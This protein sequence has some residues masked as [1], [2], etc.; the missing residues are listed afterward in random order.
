MQSHG[1]GHD[2]TPRGVARI[3]ALPEDGGAD[4]WEHLFL[5]PG[6]KQR[7]LNQ[8][9]FSLAH[10]H[11]LRSERTALHGLLVLAGPPGTGKTSTARALASVAAARLA[12]QGGTTLVEIDPH[13]LPSEMLGESQRNV[14][15]LLTSTLPDIAG[16]RT[17]TICIVDEVEALAMRRSTAS[18][19]TNP[20]DLHRAT[21]AVLTGLDSVAAA[22][23]HLLIIATTNFPAAVDEAVLSRADLVVPF[24]VPDHTA[25]VAILRDTLAELAASWPSLEGIVDDEARLDELG[26]AC[27]GYD[28][29]RLRKLVL[30]AFTLRD[31]TAL[32]PGRLTFDDLFV[33][34]DVGLVGR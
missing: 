26:K 8:A 29:R 22:H 23:P 17:F 3:A 33:A 5:S 21:D 24:D 7:L 6:T 13:A 9:L 25:T 14:A 16:K 18:F 28:G 10:R 1:H 19:D 32:D 12:P 31:E 34:A 20:A 2:A 15:K 11:R 4:A 27:A 30:T